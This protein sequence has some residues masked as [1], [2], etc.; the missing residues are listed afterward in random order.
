MI[1]ENAN[2]F[3]FCSVILHFYFC[4]LHF[5]RAQ[6]L[7]VFSACCKVCQKAG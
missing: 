7:P 6:D 1:T 4:F 5:V 3:N 2:F